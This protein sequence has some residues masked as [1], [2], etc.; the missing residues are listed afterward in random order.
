MKRLAWCVLL[1]LL[2][3]LATVVWA[4]WF[5]GGVLWIN[6]TLGLDNGSGEWYLF[7]SGFGANFAEY[8]ILITLT[9][10]AVGAYRKH[11]CHTPRCWRLSRH[12][13]E[14]ADGTKHP[15]CRHHHPK[16]HAGNRPTVAYIAEHEDLKKA[17]A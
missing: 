3:G 9:S 7:W 10:I 4:I 16:T 12:E 15:L 5:A 6:H 17:A 1:V 11:N 13:W 2:V 14:D 8:G